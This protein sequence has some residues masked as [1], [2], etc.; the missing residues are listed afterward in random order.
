METL[1]ETE[2]R[3]KERFLLRQDNRNNDQRGNQGNQQ[4]N[5]KR[6]PDNT[7]A[8][9]EQPKKAFQQPPQTFDDLLAQQ[10]PFHPHS[11]HSALDY[12]QLRGRGL[13]TRRNYQRND[14]DKGKGKANQ[15]QDEPQ[16]PAAEEDNFQHP[17]G[18]IS[19]IFCGIADAA[20]K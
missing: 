6:G 4:Q 5:R 8:T 16:A 14:Q 11:K 1:I 2:E 13:N 20:T 3:T 9:T 18:Q 12:K 17:K 10:C 15:Q 19:I 7:V